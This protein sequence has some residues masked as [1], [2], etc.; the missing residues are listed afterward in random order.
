VIPQEPIDY[1]GS[2]MVIVAK[3]FREIHKEILNKAVAHAK[4]VNA[5][6]AVSTELREGDPATQ[7]VAV[8]KEGGFDAVVV[9]HKGVG[10]VKEMLL[11]NVSEKVAHLAPCPVI[12][13]R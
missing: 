4:I 11:G 13:V 8:A 12:I 1:S 6:I 3:N 7:I 9:G 5:G 2:G 10:R